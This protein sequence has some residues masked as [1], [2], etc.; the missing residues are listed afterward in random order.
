M[1]S[2]FVYWKLVIKGMIKGHRKCFR[3]SWQKKKKDLVA[4]EARYHITCIERSSLHKY[5]KS[6]NR[7]TVGQPVYNNEQEKFDIICKW[8][9]SEEEIYSMSEIYCKMKDLVGEIT[10]FTQ[11]DGLKLSKKKINMERILCSL[12]LLGSQMLYVLRTW[13]N[14]S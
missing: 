4:S 1:W 7:T 8:L 5:Q 12:K 11:S 9:E 10:T 3:L 2:K 6:S 14:L 13:L